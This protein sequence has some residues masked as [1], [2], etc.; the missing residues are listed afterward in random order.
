MPWLIMYTKPTSRHAATRALATESFSSAVLLEVHFAKLTIGMP[1]SDDPL[2]F[3]VVIAMT[4]RYAIGAYEQR[5]GYMYIQSADSLCREIQNDIEAKWPKV[6][7]DIVVQVCIGVVRGSHIYQSS[8][9]DSLRYY[10]ALIYQGPTSKQRYL[11][12]IIPASPLKVG[13][14]I[15]LLPLILQAYK[16]CV[17]AISFVIRDSR[18]ASAYSMPICWINCGRSTLPRL[19]SCSSYLC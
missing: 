19:S 16:I 2:V 12:S 5:E 18:S 4:A 10:T 9:S 3:V 8:L 7:V 14:G 11:I 15:G 13:Y 6:K 1:D 17:T